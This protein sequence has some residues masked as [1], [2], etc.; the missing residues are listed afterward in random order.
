MAQRTFRKSSDFKTTNETAVN[1]K[2]AIVQGKVEILNDELVFRMPLVVTE[3]MIRLY[4]E[5]VQRNGAEIMVDKLGLVVA[6]TIPE[7]TEITVSDWVNAHGEPEARTF[8]VK[9]GGMAANRYI[10]LGADP[11]NGYVKVP[12]S[13]TDDTTNDGEA[14][15]AEPLTQSA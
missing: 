11:N 15:E 5:P 6:C 4:T 7:G 10:N 9:R 2:G 1:D 8:H 3:S 12:V 13:K 14:Q